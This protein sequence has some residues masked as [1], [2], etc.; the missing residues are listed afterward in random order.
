MNIINE[1]EIIL[2]EE[3]KKKRNFVDFHVKRKR[4]NSETF[5]KSPP[6]LEHVEMKK[7]IYK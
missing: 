1:S 3:L 5:K 2:R 7:R 4:K 6:F